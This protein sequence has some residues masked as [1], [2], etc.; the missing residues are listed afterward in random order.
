MQNKKVLILIAVAAVAVIGLGVHFLQNTDGMPGA[1]IGT[2]AVVTGV[3]GEPRD[4]VV[5]YY[6][7]WLK[8]AAATSTTPSDSGLTNAAFLNTEVRTYLSEALEA[9]AELDPLLCQ[10][11]LPDRLATK[12]ILETDEKATFVVTGRT[13]EKTKLLGQSVVT[14]SQTDGLWTID[15]VQCD[16]SAMLEDREFTFEH[17]GFL[18]KSVPEPLNSDFWHLVFIENDTPGHTAP[19]YFDENSM[20]TSSDGITTVCDEST[21]VEPTEVLVQGQMSEVGVAVVNVEF[22]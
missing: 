20:C 4:I 12:P 17:Q 15:S 18:L 19:L 22:K 11:I 8:A 10:N 5:E 9:S 14:L 13:A 1:G 6:L 21:F 3:A 7:D 2:D 16:M